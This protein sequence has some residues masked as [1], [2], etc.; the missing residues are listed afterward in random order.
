LKINRVIFIALSLGVIGGAQAQTI[1][2]N[3]PIDS[4][5]M[6]GFYQGDLAQSFIQTAGDIDGAGIFTQPGVGSGSGDIT[7]SLYDNL[8]NAGGNLL[9]SGT[10]DNAVSN[11]WVDVS[12]SDLSI[13]AGSTYY[14]VF[15][16]TN[17]SLGIGG[18][19]ANPY[20]NGEVYANPGYEGFPGYG[21]TFRTYHSD[22]VPEPAPFAALG[23][24]VL[25]LVRRRRS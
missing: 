18:S 14:L 25:A 11:E 20:P 22:A 15:T 7:I 6:A 13:T 17:D 3:Q 19:T 21:Y 16:S 12:W 4:V 9:T 10:F 2:Q 5:Y 23:L 1:D 24:G 8:P